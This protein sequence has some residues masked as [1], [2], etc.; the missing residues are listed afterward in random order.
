MLS[1]ENSFR[2]RSLRTAGILGADYQAGVADVTNSGKMFTKHL[3]S[4]SAR[5]LLDTKTR[6]GGRSPLASACAKVT[7]MLPNLQQCQATDAQVTTGSNPALRRT[8]R[9][10]SSL[11]DSLPTN[12]RRWC[13]EAT[14]APRSPAHPEGN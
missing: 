8:C 13:T 7:S 5:S 10:A 2:T 6:T 12:C 1:A 14:A 3:W 11:P 9:S 4:A